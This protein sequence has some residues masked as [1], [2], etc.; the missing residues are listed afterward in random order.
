LCIA[1]L[2]LVEEPNYEKVERVRKSGRH[3]HGKRLDD[4]LVLFLSCFLTASFASK[5]FLHPRLL[6]WLQ[7]KGVT[8]HFLDDVFLLDLALEA[9]KRVFE[10][11]SLMNA[12][13]RQKN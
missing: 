7:V 11:F 12:N 3:P 6:A 4:L 13:F 8:F 2:L 1:R 9:P 5:R 10:G